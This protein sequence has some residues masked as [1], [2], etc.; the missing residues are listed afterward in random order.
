MS[1]PR[2]EAFLARLY[3]DDAFRRG[4]SA[5]PSA[6]ASS[7]ELTRA[8]TE[9]ALAIDLEALEAAGRSFGHKRQRKGTPMS[10]VRTSPW[11]ALSSRL[12][13]WARPRSSR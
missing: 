11:R 12:R 2:F 10:T 13:W 4:F 6:V 1:S 8:E 5:A 3:S 7:E 9:A